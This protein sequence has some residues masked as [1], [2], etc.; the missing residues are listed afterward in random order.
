MGQDVKDTFERARHLHDVECAP[1]LR[2]SS[3]DLRKITWPAEIYV[4]SVDCAVSITYTIAACSGAAARP[5]S[6]ELVRQRGAR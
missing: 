6:L 4:V 5:S 2:R 1:S 3:N